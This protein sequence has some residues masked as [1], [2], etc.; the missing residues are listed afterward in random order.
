[1]GNPAGLSPGLVVAVAILGAMVI[2]CGDSDD[3][4][5]T[6]TGGAGSGGAH[7]AASPPGRYGPAP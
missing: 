6:G 7:V 1:M 5:A 2:T 4:T 3:T